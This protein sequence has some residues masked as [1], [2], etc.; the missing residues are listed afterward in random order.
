V[1][2]SFCGS[3]LNGLPLA[4]VIPRITAAYGVIASRRAAKRADAII[5]KSKALADRLTGIDS[6][7]VFVI[8]NGVDMSLFKPLDRNECLDRLG[9]SRKAY[10]VLTYGGEFGKRVELIRDA[11]T[12]AS[13][14][15]GSPIELHVLSGVARADVP[16][17]LNASHAFALASA[18]EG[19]PNVVKEAL[20]CDVPVISTDVGD[21]RERTEGVAGCHVVD[22][23]VDAFCNGLADAVTRG[24]RA[25]GRQAMTQ[26]SLEAT[27]RRV[28]DVYD[29]VLAPVR[30]G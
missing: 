3:D 10:H 4:P 20:A 17:W 14:K 30:H 22:A 9:W 27:A 23:T 28:A 26:L 24:G 5:T 21:V 6:S 16:V 13:A 1:V 25:P 2:V 8:P 29:T 19:S 15:V 12:A 7:N 18:L 11:V